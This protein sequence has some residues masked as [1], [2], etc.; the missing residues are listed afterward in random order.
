VSRLMLPSGDDHPE[1]AHKHLLDAGALLNQQ[2][3]D[4]AAYLSGYVVE[5]SLKSLF[6][7]ET[8]RPLTGHGIHSLLA[9]VS[10]VAAAAG[11]RAARYLGPAT[12]GVAASAVSGWTPEMRYRAPWMAMA[13]AASWH[14]CARDVFQETVHQMRL[15]GVL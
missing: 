8:G 12:M 1:A 4:G 2:R 3:P 13:D 7:H 10:R 9:Q 15:D 5:C 14:T 6:V 11:S